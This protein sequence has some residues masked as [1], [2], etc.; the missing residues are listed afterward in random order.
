MRDQIIWTQAQY[1]VLHEELANRPC[2]IQVDGDA[3]TWIPPFPATFRF[4]HG[5]CSRESLDAVADAGLAA[6]QWSVA[7]DDLSR[8][9]TASEIAGRI[10]RE[11]KPGAIVM[12]HANGRGWNTA[13]GLALAIPELQKKG[14]RFV[15]VSELLDAGT[16]LTAQ[17]CDDLKS[18]D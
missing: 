12:A 1:A 4:P 14:Y 18:G 9:Q 15:T 2:A 11:A 6:I 16:P 17:N 3:M 5:T 7:I 13:E 8:T 10:L